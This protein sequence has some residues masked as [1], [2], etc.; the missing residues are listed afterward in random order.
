[1][2]LLGVN[3]NVTSGVRFPLTERIYISLCLS[4]RCGDEGTEDAPAVTPRE[5]QWK[6]LKRLFAAGE[7]I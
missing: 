1:V 7:I 6:F 2:W 5:F 4:G 3:H